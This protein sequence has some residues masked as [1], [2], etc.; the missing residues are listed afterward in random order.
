MEKKN[1][2]SGLNTQTLPL[3][4][5]LQPMWSLVFVWVSQTHN[6]R[7]SHFSWSV[8]LGSKAWSPSNSEMHSL[9]CVAS[10]ETCAF[11]WVNHLCYSKNMNTHFLICL[12]VY[13]VCAVQQKIIISVIMYFHC[14]TVTDTVLFLSQ[15]LPCSKNVSERSTW[16]NFFMYKTLQI[17][18]DRTLPSSTENIL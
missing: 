10:G 1:Y 17:I 9:V 18:I 6:R 7:N 16:H 8:Q 5:C 11:I 2:F 4:F 3:H 14:H 13:K 12:N 15:D